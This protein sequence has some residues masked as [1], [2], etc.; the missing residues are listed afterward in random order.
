[1]LYGAHRGG[2]ELRREPDGA[3]RLAGRFPYGVETVLAPAAGTR[4]ELREVFAPRAFAA[5]I[6]AGEEVHLLSH[7]DYDR[8]LASRGAGTLEVQDTADALTFEA[9][10]SAELR[11][12][13]YVA[14]FLGA[15]E[16]GLIRGLSPGFRIGGGREEVRQTDGAMIRTVHAAELFELSAVTVPAYSEAQIEA[17][18]WRDGTCPPG[19]CH[20]SPY[21]Q[22]F[23]RWRA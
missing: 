2:L 17:R 1:M 13:P 23:N 4:P 10:I 15:L 12:A 9:T 16:A 18:R 6:D 19:T 3:L 14:D 20:P 11:R 5:R 21:A 22:A 8:P 7:H